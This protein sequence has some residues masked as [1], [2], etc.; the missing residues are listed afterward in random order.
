MHCAALQQVE[1]T[2]Y[3]AASRPV[4]RAV[5]MNPAVFGALPDA[6]SL[7]SPGSSGFD[8]VT[9]SGYDAAGQLVS[10]RAA[11]GL[12]SEQVSATLTWTANGLV[13]TVK[14]AKGNLTTFEYDGFDR[15]I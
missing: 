11:V 2:S 10:V 5:R 6:C 9:K 12:S 7:S 8:R 15:L 4:C 14:D 1:Q 3:D 13:K